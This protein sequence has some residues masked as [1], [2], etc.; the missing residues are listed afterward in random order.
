M[1]QYLFFISIFLANFILFTSCSDDLDTTPKTEFSEVAVWSDPA[2]VETFVNNIYYRLDEPLTGGRFKACLV[3]EA[4]YRGN[5]GSFDFNNCLMTSDNIPG[6]SAASR[7]RVWA[8]VYKTIRNCNLFFENVDKVTFSDALVDGK[9]TKDRI[10]GEV[11]FLRAYNYFNLVNLYGGVPLITNVYGLEDDFDAPR[12]TF[13]ECIDFIVSEC[14]K[15][16]NLLP[17]ANTGANY[18]RATKGAALALKSRTLLYA[19]SDLYSSTKTIFPDY[20][21]PELLGYTGGD[22]TS[23]WRA[24]KDA[25]KA[26]IDMGI[27]KLYKPDPAPT[28]SIA[29]NLVDLFKSKESEEDIFVK[30]FTPVMGQMMGLYSGPNGFHCWGS[31]APLGDLVDDYEMKD[32]TKFDWNKPEHAAD[33]YANRE[34]RFYATILYNGSYYRPRTSDVTGIEPDGIVQT[35]R[36]EIWDPE[37]NTVQE[38]YGV[39]TRK[40][41]IEDWNGSYTGYYVRKFMDPAIDASVYIYQE[42]TWRFFRYGEILLN[43][44]EACIELG[45]YDEAKTYINQIRK[46]AGLPGLTEEGEALKT[47]YRNERRIELAFEEHR[48]FDVRRWAVGAEAYHPVKQAT[49]IYKL[50][51]DKTTS[52]VPTITHDVW[53]TRKWDNKAYFL[54]ILRAEMNKNAALVQNPGY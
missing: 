40:S 2:L 41:A 8:D 3:D 43:Y 37:T 30:F 1:K 31:N 27:Y 20:S 33:P 38:K 11:T 39:D 10:T 52:T 47:R 9:T 32:G 45:E 5:S 16:A 54:P 12:N 44:A 36:W 15:A 26:V 35:G 48:F 25:A 34:Q 49:I 24:A 6:F 42:V 14:D 13:E 53:E 18:G 7:Y 46:R 17:V 23:R 51:E 28:D 21:N 22:L 29:Q 4:H 19:A 50:N